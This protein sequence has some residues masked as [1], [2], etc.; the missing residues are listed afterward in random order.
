VISRIVV[1]IPA[2][3][4][5][6]EINECLTTVDAAIADLHAHTSV[7]G[8]VVVALDDCR[9]D[10][11]AVVARFPHVRVV[12]T[13]ARR[14]GAARRAAADYALSEFGPAGRLWLA[15]TDADCRVPSSWLTQ[16]AATAAD[17]SELVLGTLRLA[18]G[19]AAPVEQAWYARHDLTDGHPHVHGA[20]LGIAAAAYVRIGGWADLAV[21]EDTDLVERAIAAGLAIARSGASPVVTSARLTGRAPQGFASYLDGLHEEA[22]EAG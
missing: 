9:D 1:T 6:D 13:S 8:H 19:L 3:D 14:V 18:P 20:N 16:Q 4:E 7:R 22:A 12:E 15:S 10:T 11:A 5:Q 21:H 2:A 17:G